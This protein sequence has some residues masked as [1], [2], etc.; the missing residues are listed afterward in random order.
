M[1]NKG[2]VHNFFIKLNKLITHK[3]KIV[4]MYRILTQC[5][6]DRGSVRN[7]VNKKNLC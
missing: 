5:T 2:N 3:K 6:V 1:I 4:E 7:Y